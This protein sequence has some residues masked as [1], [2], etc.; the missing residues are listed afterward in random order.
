M[1]GNR[2]FANTSPPFHGH[3]LYFKMPSHSKNAYSQT[4]LMN[5][6]KKFKVSQVT[7]VLMD[8]EKKIQELAQTLKNNGL[9]A[10]MEDA[11]EAARRIFS[12]S[13]KKPIP[14]MNRPEKQKDIVEASKPEPTAHQTYEKQE[15]VDQTEN[16]AELALAESERS[17]KD[18]MD[19][20][21]QE[22]Y[23]N[24]DEMKPESRELD[25]Q[26]EDSQESANEGQLQEPQ[27]K[28]PE[29]TEF[30]V[31]TEDELR[32]TEKITNLQDM[33]QSS[34]Q[35]EDIHKDTQENHIRGDD[36]APSE[37]IQSTQQ[38]AQPLSENTGT[39]KTSSPIESTEDIQEIIQDS[40]LE[41]IEPK[42]ESS[43]SA[44][45][46]PAAYD[47]H[48]VST[49]QNPDAATRPS[50]QEDAE[51]I[52]PNENDIPKPKIE[53]QGPSESPES[54]QNIN[55]NITELPGKL[56]ENSPE[57]TPKQEF[58]QTDTKPDVPGN[59]QHLPI[60]SE[61]LPQDNPRVETQEQIQPQEDILSEEETL[62]SQEE[63]DSQSTEEPRHEFSENYQRPIENSI[64]PVMPSALGISAEEDNQANREIQNPE[65]RPAKDSGIDPESL[66]QDTGEN[67]PNIDTHQPA[68]ENMSAPGEPIPQPIQ[69]AQQQPGESDFIIN[70]KV[71]D[72]QQ[73]SFESHPQENDVKAQSSTAPNEPSQQQPEASSETKQQSLNP[74]NTA[75]EQKSSSEQPKTDEKKKKI[76]LSEI[77]NFGKRNQ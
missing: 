23:D 9:A 25:E 69:E 8:K 43:T 57:L 29:K 54:A 36:Q 16:E 48:E 15:P 52:L 27:K 60:E 66:L 76:D 21:A 50:N 33:D 35:K 22:I 18:L 59:L 3:F 20:D 37:S 12:D 73:E 28:E 71:Q 17:I 24:E 63:E 30:I 47:L 19:E 41:Q 74:D 44:Q 6:S 31:K 1:K 67:M 39:A 61:Q 42:E 51:T 10:S 46:E 5:H 65:T 58:T 26:H 72:D 34:F 62:P 53:E 49:S 70:T 13:S 68:Q 56:T 45:Q 38:P 75:A 40:M 4:Y 64:E 77:F 7:T 11:L 2:F 14:K 55:K 32:S